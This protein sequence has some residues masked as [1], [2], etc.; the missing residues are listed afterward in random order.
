MNVSPIPTTRIDKDQPEDQIIG[1]LNSA[2]KTRKMTKIFDEHAM[3]PK[4]VIQSLEDPRWVEAMQE[5][6]LNKKDERRFVVRNKARLVAQGYT[7]E[8]GIDYDEVFAPVARIEEIR[9]LLAYASFIRFIVYHMD[10][11]SAF[12]YGTIEDEVYVCQPPGFEDPHFPDKVYKVEKALYG[13]HQALKAWKE[14]GDILLVQVY[15]DDI[16]FGSTKK[17]LC[18]EFEGLMYKRFQMSSMGELTFFLGLQVQQKKDGIFISQDKYVAE[19]LKKFDFATVKTTSTPMEPNKA[20]VKDEEADNVDVHLYTSMIGSLMY[21]TASRPDIMFAVCACARFQVTPKTL[22]LHAVKRI[23]R[24]LKG[25][26]KLGLWY[27]RDSPFDLEAFSD[28]DYAGASLDRKSTTG[29]YVAAAHCCGHN[30]VFHSKTK[31]IEIRHH[32]IRDSYEKKL[33]QVIKIHIDYN[34]AYLLTKAFDVSRNVFGSKTGSCKI[35]AAR[36]A[37]HIEYLDTKI[38][39]SSGPPKKVDDEAVH[40]E[41]GDRMER[42]ATTAS[43]LEAEQDSASLRRHLKLEDADGISSLPNTEIFEQLALMGYASDSDKLTFQTCLFKVQFSRV[44]DQQSQLSPITCLSLLIHLTTT[45][46]ITLQV[47]SLEQDLKQTKKVYSNAYTKLIMRVKKLEHKVKS[48]QPRR[49]RRVVISDTEE[50]LEDPSK[51][52]RRIAEIDQNPSISLVQ[53]K[54]TS[55]I[56][57]DTGIQGRTSADTEILL[58][59]EEPTKLVGDLGSGEKGEKEIS[60][61]NI[62]VST[63]SATPKVSTTSENLVYI[64]RS[65]EK[66]K[67][68]GKA[69][70][71]EDESVEKRTKKQ[72]EQERLGHKEAIRLQEQI[73]EEERQRIDRDAEIA[74]QLQEEF[75]RARQEQEVVAEADQA[76]DID[77]SGPAILRYHAVQNRSFSKAKVRKNMC[78]YLK[79]QGGYKMSHFK[80]MSYKDIR[81]I[82]ERCSKKRSRDDSDEDNAKKHKLED[83]AEKK[84]LRDSIDV[85]LRDDIVIDVESLATKYPIVD[86]KTH[87]FVNQVSKRFTQTTSQRFV[88]TTSR[89]FDELLDSDKMAEENVPAPTR[90]DEQLVPVKARLLIGKSKLLMDLQKNFQ[91]NELWFNLNADLLRNALEITPKDSAHPFVLPLVNEEG[92][93]KKKVMEAGKRSDHLVD[94]K[95]KESQ[96]ASKPQVEDDEYKLQRGIQMSLKY[97]QAP[98]GGLSIREPE[99]VIARKIPEVEGKGKGIVSDEQAAQSLI[100]LQKPKKKSTTDQY[101]LQIQSPVTL[102]ASTGPSTQPHDDT[103]PKV[104][105]DTLSPVDST[106]DAK[107]GVDTEKYNSEMN[108]EILYFKEEQGEEVSNMV[109]REERTVELYEG[110]AGSDPSKTPESQ[111]SPE[112]KLMEE[113]HDGPNPGQSH[114]AQAG[115]NSEPMHEDFIATIYP[116]VHE[117]LKLT[118]KEQTHIENPPISSGTLSSMNNHDDAFTF[119][120]QFLNDKSLEEELKKANVE[121]EVKSM[122]TVPIHQASSSLENH[123]LYSK[124]DKQVNEVVK[125]AVNNALQAS[126][127]K[128]FR[129]LS[130]FQMKEILHDQMLESGSY[131]SHPDHSALYEALEASMQRENNDELHEALTT[132][133]K[134]HRDDQDPTQPPPK[135]SD[136]SKKKKQDFN[137]S[138]SK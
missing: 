9:L 83:D 2:I 7:Q 97:F 106:N 58:D 124:I 33:I 13:L 23:F 15:V 38:P 18:D 19:I 137:T 61:A 107:T 73:N 74:K 69:I 96:L 128:R 51:Q 98:V 39:Q 42:A 28:S 100:D 108:T 10:V 31:H 91:L 3:E 8:K 135:D 57:V 125:E 122:V 117:N 118:T 30:L 59:Q 112:S 27:P 94:E 44:K 46:F 127:C 56:Q 53:D 64:R 65:A 131:R 77:W 71:K 133:R 75:D 78:I 109:S 79:N 12:L 121:T 130:E 37:K 54:G 66:R 89:Q 40:K 34:V 136:R 80:G 16:I 115:L 45:T 84:E 93:K 11:K 68:K 85:V 110:Q 62:S 35:N 6:L 132:S 32:F 114:V 134:R 95:D 52:G 82:F 49:R 101:I 22:H 48:R 116:K 76:H 63:A 67:D 87:R 92:G 41:L 88:Q 29:E 111:P 104:V 103:S 119:G 26:P 123:D 47:A 90:T 70:M 17:Y 20:L 81:P 60:A 105:H 1:D 21:L 36:Q 4:K 129:H 138:T 99:S 14:K 120:D 72:L 50:D 5:E 25:Q 55:W 86:W 24:Y 43:S 113:D 126:L 102:D